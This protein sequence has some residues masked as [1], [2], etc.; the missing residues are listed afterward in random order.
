MTKVEIK[1]EALSTECSEAYKALRTNLL[2]CGDDKKTI[3]FTS[4]T[5]DEGKST[6]VTYLA[7]SM[8]EA[9]KR[10]LVVDADLRKSV[11]MGNFAIG[12]AIRGL[13]HYLSGQAAMADVICCTNQPGLEIIFAGPVVPNPAELLG[14][15]RFKEL[16][17]YGRAN[18]DY[19]LVDSAPLGSV[20]DAAIIAE[21]C[22][23]SVIVIEAEVISWRFVQEI[24]EQLEKSS[25][26]ILGTVLNKVDVRSQRYYSHY[27]GKKYRKYYGSYYGYGEY[28]NRKK[29]N[30]K[31]K[32]RR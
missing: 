13:T 19:V 16:L 7:Q 17:A 12:E 2:F 22:D 8:A 18:Y 1:A 21:E 28:G 5:P 30:H 15:S 27:Y 4:C 26:P 24:K 20:I 31:R 25:C 32:E 29:K 10:V 9:G 11:M 23:G 3:V 6:V 14:D